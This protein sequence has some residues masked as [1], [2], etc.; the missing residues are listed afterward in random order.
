MTTFIDIWRFLSGHTNQAT[1]ENVIQIG[2]TVLGKVNQHFFGRTDGWTDTNSIQNKSTIYGYGQK[3][4]Y[5]R[6]FYLFAHAISFRIK[7]IECFDLFKK[8]DN[9]P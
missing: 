8:G 9:S 1:T 4:V 6:F 2:P 5:L 7:N 3:F